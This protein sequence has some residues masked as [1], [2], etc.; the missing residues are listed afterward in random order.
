MPDRY[1]PGSQNALGIVG[2]GEAVG[3][4]LE[5]RE[6]LERHEA[7]LREAMIEGLA[8]LDALGPEFG[9]LGLRLLGP[10]SAEGRVGVFSLLHETLSAHEL[11]ALMESRYGVLGRAGLHCAPRAHAMLGTRARGGAYRLSVGP[12]VSVGD[13]RYACESLGEACRAAVSA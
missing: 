10:A 4:I 13:V 1:E 12:F 5:R 7:S 3:W 6:E 9:S 8:A 2:L 11:A